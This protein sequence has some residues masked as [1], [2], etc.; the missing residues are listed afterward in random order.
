MELVCA[1]A[2]GVLEIEDA[3]RAL[4]ALAPRCVLVLSGRD[5]RRRMR[6][7]LLLERAIRPA[8]IARDQ[9]THRFHDIDVTFKTSNLLK[10]RASKQLHRPR[11]CSGMTSSLLDAMWKEMLWAGQEPKTA[12]HR[13]ESGTG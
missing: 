7:H 8:T 4:R 2:V 12:A 11:M 1:A 10:M 13:I 3:L 5:V 6:T 9:P